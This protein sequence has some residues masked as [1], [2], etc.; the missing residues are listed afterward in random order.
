[1]AS[2]RA[3]VN[4]VC[5]RSGKSRRSSSAAKDGQRA[6]KRANKAFTSEADRDEP[7]GRIMEHANMLEQRGF[8]RATLPDTIIINETLSVPVK[9]NKSDVRTEI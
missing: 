7:H 6:A 1:M 2:N 5:S 8:P 4:M 3:V 9:V